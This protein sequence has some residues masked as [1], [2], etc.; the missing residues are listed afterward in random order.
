VRYLVEVLHTVQPVISRQLS[1]LRRAGLVQARR[2]GKWIHYRLHTPENQPASELLS[3]A[4][5]QLKGVRQT[6]MDLARLAAYSQ[7]R[8]G[9]LKNA[10]LPQRVTR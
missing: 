5:R 2:D 4:L 3:E 9:Q 1:A 8:T 7:R 10:P 6:Q